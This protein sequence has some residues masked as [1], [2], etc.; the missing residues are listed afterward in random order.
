MSVC[1]FSSYGHHKS[2]HVDICRISC[3]A[4]RTY[5]HDQ[6]ACVYKYIVSTVLAVIIISPS[7]GWQPNLSFERFIQKGPPSRRTKMAQRHWKHIESPR[8]GTLSQAR[9]SFPKVVWQ[10][11]PLLLE[12]KKTRT[13]WASPYSVYT[14]FLYSFVGLGIPLHLVS[15]KVLLQTKASMEHSICCS[16]DFYTQHYLT[17]ETPSA[18]SWIGSTSAFLLMTVGLVSGSLHDRGYF[19]HLIIAGSFLQGFCLF[20]LSLS[21]PDQYYQIFLSQGL[22]LGIALGLLYIPS[23]AV[24]SHHFRRKRTLVMAFVAT[25]LITRCH[26]PSD[27]TQ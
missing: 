25:G 15:I 3:P 27:H 1:K 16:P 20:M 19:Y 7:P 17:N 6:V 13:F 23:V 11:G 5:G 26:H 4:R 22:G 18:I 9:M 14:G 24:I 12:R 8:I 21:K 2:R 10:L